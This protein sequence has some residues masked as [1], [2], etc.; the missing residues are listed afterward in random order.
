MK[1]PSWK[2]TRCHR[3]Y[4][5]GELER[6]YN[7]LIASLNGNTY[8]KIQ[9]AC[10]AIGETHG[11]VPET[12]RKYY[13]ARENGQV[14]EERINQACAVACCYIIPDKTR[15]KLLKE[16]Q[17]SSNIAGDFDEYW[18]EI[19]STLL[20]PEVA[21]FALAM[22]KVLPHFHKHM[23]GAD[24]PK[25]YFS[26]LSDATEYLKTS[27]ENKPD[28]HKTA[29]RDD[30]ITIALCAMQIAANARKEGEE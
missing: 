22:E 3:G 7:L 24:F 8:R 12:L 18:A 23:A 6:A 16:K 1:A 19:E 10:R 17:E 9:P 29:I 11:I 15:Y 25:H 26:E 4:P 30:S 14:C 21:E 27:L 2:T 13:Y 20:S 28:S 5:N